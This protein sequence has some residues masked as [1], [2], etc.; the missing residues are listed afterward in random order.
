M[1]NFTQDHISGKTVASILFIYCFICLS[2]IQEEV[3]DDIDLSYPEQPVVLCTL[4]PGDSIRL[5]LIRSNNLNDNTALSYQERG[6]FDA[7]V[8]IF[9]DS[10][11][12]IRL[13]PGN[14]LPLYKASQQGF[15]ILPGN[16]YRLVVNLPNSHKLTASTWVPERDIKWETFDVYNVK[17]ERKNFEVGNEPGNPVHQK[18]TIHKSIMARWVDRENRTKILLSYEIDQEKYDFHSVLDANHP[19]AYINHTS[20]CHT[21]RMENLLV[22]YES[23]NR[24]T[25]KKQ[26]NIFHLIT[27]NDDLKAYYRMYDLLFSNDED[28]E[29]G[30]FLP[31]FRGVIPEYDNSE[32]GMGIFGA[33][34]VSDQRTVE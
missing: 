28:V 17:E 8:F 15:P 11:D 1:S 16:V 26:K 27:L 7:K 3:I 2:C 20:C 34:V 24:N 21:L 13:L 22:Y 30:Q 5:M 29:T 9:N 23:T 32:G 19:R 12:S 4:T 14:E 33:F 6:I 31:L 18:F 10:N 25:V